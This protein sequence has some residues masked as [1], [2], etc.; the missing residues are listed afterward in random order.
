MS[1]YKCGHDRKPVLLTKSVVDYSAYLEW[2]GS[3]GFEGDKSECWR[4]FCNRLNKDK[5]E[6][7]GKKSIYFDR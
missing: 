5:G 2:I 7:N 4:C 1:F 6:S 3:T